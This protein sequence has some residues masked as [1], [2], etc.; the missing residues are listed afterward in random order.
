MLQS[1]GNDGHSPCW[2]Q[3][4][5]AAFTFSVSIVAASGALAAPRPIEQ[6]IPNPPLTKACGLNVLMILD[7]SGS[8][9]TSN[10]T[11]DVRNAF[12]AFTD[13]I[14]NTS[15]AMAVAEFSRVARLPAIGGFPPRKY[16]T[17][18]D[19]TKVDFDA[20]INNDF[21]PN[22]NT[23]WED[24]LRM[25]IPKFLPRDNFQVPHLTVFITDGDPN[26][27]I[28][29]SVT[30]TDYADKVPLADSQTT[31]ANQNTAAD[32]AVANANNLKTQGSR[33]LAIAVGAGLSSNA[34]LNRLIRV[35]GPNVYNGTGDFDISTDDIYREPD[36]S[37][38]QDALRQTRIPA[39]RTLGHGAEIDRSDP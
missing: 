10:A 13:A 3:L 22:G 34:S 36:F 18:T 16:I 15:S 12:K 25:G 37:K 23:N 29:D 26:Q 7:E 28:R 35:S 5:A 19:S 6:P 24:G 21:N 39:L 14:K 4:C 38:L 17:V 30:A 9:G 31:G 11:Q 33:I 1:K 32:H 8:I 2:V 27:I 20:Y